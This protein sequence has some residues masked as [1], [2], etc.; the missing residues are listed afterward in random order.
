MLVW[1]LKM[2]RREKFVEAQKLQI[3]CVA[4]FLLVVFCVGVRSELVI[5]D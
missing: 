5:F 2:Q 4:G 3:L 1:V